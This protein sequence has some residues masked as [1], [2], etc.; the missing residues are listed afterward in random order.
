MAS[1][2][3]VAW[4]MAPACRVPPDGGRD[5]TMPMRVRFVRGKSQVH[6]SPWR[7]RTVMTVSGWDVD[8]AGHRPG[9]RDAQKLRA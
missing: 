2:S 9:S 3:T 5:L 8:I 6:Q 1:P 4:L 7:L